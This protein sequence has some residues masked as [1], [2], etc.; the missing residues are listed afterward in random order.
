M[1]RRLCRRVVLASLAGLASL[2]AHGAVAGA[3]ATNAKYPATAP[4]TKEAVGAFDVGLVKRAEALLS[5]PQKWNRVDTG[6][7]PRADTTYSVRCALQRAIVEGAGLRWDPRTA[8]KTTAANAP[9]DCAMEVSTEHP[10]GTC[11]LLWDELPVLTLERVNAVTSGV[12]RRDASPIEV[13]AGK[14]ADAEGPVHVESR[15]VELV[16]RRK[17]ADQLVDFNNDSTTTFDQVQSFFRTL[18]DRV[19]KNG[20]ADLGPPADDVE[21]EIYAGGT[22]VIRTYNGW[23]PVTAYSRNGSTLRFQMDT[24]NEIPAGPLDREILERAAKI[25]S[26]DAVWNRADNRECPAT[27][28]TWS[29]YCAVEKAEIEVTGGFHHRRP[30]GELVREIVDERAKNRNYRHRMMDYNNDPT[31]TIADVRSL[32]GEAV[33]RIR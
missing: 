27:A 22:G 31:T 20:A 26:S 30:A 29:I 5:S 4:A 19:L 15:K 14:M 13:W 18:E 2:A 17:G 1:R 12:W 7:C 16:S 23:F 3:Q 21:I 10:G 6:R 32:F 9:L 28:T 33:G 25:L 11:G 8:P 24:L